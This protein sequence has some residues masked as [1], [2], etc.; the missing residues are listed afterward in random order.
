[1]IRPSSESLPDA[2]QI[3]RKF[4]PSHA[5][6]TAFHALVSRRLEQRIYAPG[7]PLAFARTTYL[8]T[9]DLHYY[10]SQAR[11]VARRLRLREYAAAASTGPPRLT[12]VAFLELKSTSAGLRSKVRLSSPPPLTARLLSSELDR[13]SLLALAGRSERGAIRRLLRELAGR[14]LR[15]RVT[16]WYQ[17]E[18]FVD[19]DA[20]IRVTFDTETTFCR[21]AR[22]RPPGAE[23][24]PRQIIGHG[25]TYVVEIK[26]P[27]TP[28]RW[29]AAAMQPLRYPGVISKYDLGMRAA[30]QATSAAALRLSG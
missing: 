21:P 15:A 14:T 3:E 12:G 27:T 24:T 29:L 22:G 16:T 13:R 26:Y 30:M 2:F 10:H 4:V 1:M 28:P 25:P 11:G 6:M 18:S 19:A 23:V 17:R 7:R 20:D 8:D 5:E 9:A